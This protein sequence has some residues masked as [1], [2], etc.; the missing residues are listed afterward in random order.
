MSL[1]PFTVLAA[2]SI[3]STSWKCIFMEWDGS[4]FKHCHSVRSMIDCVYTLLHCNTHTVLYCLHSLSWF[5]FIDF[6]SLQSKKRRTPTQTQSFSPWKTM[7]VLLENTGE[8]KCSSLWIFP[9]PPLLFFSSF[10]THQPRP[11][12]S[13]CSLPSSAL[14][15]WAG[16]PSLLSTF[17]ADQ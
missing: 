16:A 11:R 8:R 7:T 15:V 14:C 9:E 6:S 12:P 5:V 17:T 3:I 4:D 1:T 2:N 10:F 13:P